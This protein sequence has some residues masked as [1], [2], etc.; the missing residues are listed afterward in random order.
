MKIKY[1][2]PKLLTTKCGQF[3]ETQRTERRQ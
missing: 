1:N 3:F 2:L